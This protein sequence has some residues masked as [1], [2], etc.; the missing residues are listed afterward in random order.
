MVSRSERID[1]LCMPAGAWLR[2]KIVERIWCS[3]DQVNAIAPCLLGELC[4]NRCRFVHISTDMVF[5][6]DRAPYRENDP[7][8]P[9]SEYGR[10]KARA[11]NELARF[12]GACTA[13]TS[14]LFGPSLGDPLSFFDQLLQTLRDGSRFAMFTDEFRTPLSLPAAARQGYFDLG[15]QRANG[16]LESG[17]PGT[18]L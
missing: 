15:G 12:P 16:N 17:R 14:L 18:S 6:G 3:A 5:R 1:G 2:S 4:A 9:L 8:S 10:T 13:R 11:E 7:R